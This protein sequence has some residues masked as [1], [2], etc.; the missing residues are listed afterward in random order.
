M[1]ARPASD[2]DCK[3]QNGRIVFC[4]LHASAAGLL[5]ACQ[6]VRELLPNC[7]PEEDEY[8][9]TIREVVLP[10]LD[11]LIANAQGKGSKR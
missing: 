7:V 1:S 3:F 10:Q 8:A 2:C 6:S 4:A 9:K 11:S 5:A